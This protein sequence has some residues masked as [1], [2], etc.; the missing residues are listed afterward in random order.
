ML[1]DMRA[2]IHDSE[3]CTNLS[4][5]QAQRAPVRL[6]AAMDTEPVTSMFNIDI[7]PMNKRS[8][9]TSFPQSDAAALINTNLKKVSSIMKKALQLMRIKT[10]I[11]V[12]SILIAARA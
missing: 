2:I 7:S 5:K 11:S 8:G 4:S 3:C 10:M 9:E 12:I 1:W 6:I